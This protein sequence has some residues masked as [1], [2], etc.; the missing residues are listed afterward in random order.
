MHFERIV[1]P[2][3][4]IIHPFVSNSQTST[5]M[6]WI[7]RNGTDENSVHL[8]FGEEEKQAKSSLSPQLPLIAI[9]FHWEFR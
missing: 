7:E 4:E 6:P 9:H 1:H 5:R 2:F 3:I 8:H